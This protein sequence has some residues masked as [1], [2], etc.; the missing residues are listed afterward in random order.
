MESINHCLLSRDELRKAVDDVT[1]PA[2]G[3]TVELR[4]V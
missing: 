4:S 1:I 2:D 3:E